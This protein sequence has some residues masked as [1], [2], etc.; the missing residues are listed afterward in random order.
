MVELGLN[1]SLPLYRQQKGWTVANHNW[2]QVCNGGMTLGALAIGD[3]ERQLAG[4]ILPAAIASVRKP[5]REFAPDGAW[6]EGPG[7]WDY[8]VMYNVFMLAALDSALGT[9][10][11]LSQIEGF[12]KAAD[13]PIHVTGPIG[14]TF[15][16]ADAGDGGS[17]GPHV[18]WLATRF[19]RP[20]FAAFRI[21]RVRG[22]PGALDLLYG[23]HWLAG[24]LEKRP[25]P[26]L[27]KHFRAAEIVT[28]RSAWDD[29]EATFVACKGGDNRVNHGHLDLGTFVL[30]ALGERWAFDPGGDDY[31]LPGYFG[32]HRWD[33]YRLRAEGHNTLVIAPDARPDQSVRAKARIT[34]F[35]DQPGRS[36]AIIDLDEAYAGRASAA[37]RG[38][39]LTGRNVLVQDEVKTKEAPAEVW[40]FMHTGAEVKCDGA[41]ATLTQNGRHLTAT[42]LSPEGATF[43][44]LPA[45]PLATSPHPKRQ[46]VKH[47]STKGAQKVAIHLRS[48][49]SPRI[50]VLLS[51]GDEPATQF[52]ITPL[53]DWK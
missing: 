7:Y 25:P 12:A 22:R 27:A 31:N 14:R 24:P 44:V 26:P 49:T 36:F 30:D 35:S 17:G 21:A 6:G 28:M 4:E 2:N 42:L 40:W 34:R 5:M 45:E 37:Q 52:R 10:F 11:G 51:P 46:Q 19:D 32:S 1:Q 8:A 13:F 3:E 29:A 23:A 41:T 53:A 9:D 18:L 33:Y 39:L 50:A 20:D 47:T 43:D 15:N 16:S 38:I 48:A